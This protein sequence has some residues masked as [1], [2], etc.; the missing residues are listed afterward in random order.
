MGLYPIQNKGKAFL[1]MGDTKSNNMNKVGQ[2]SDSINRKLTQSVFCNALFIGSN[3][4][5][6]NPASAT[7]KVA[8]SYTQRDG[9]LSGFYTRTKL[10]QIFT[11]AL[12]V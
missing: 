10:G 8:K 4:R 7:K 5:D 11:Y 3:I 1:Y 6:L 12:V 2:D 9:D